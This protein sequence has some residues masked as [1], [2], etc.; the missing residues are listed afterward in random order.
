MSDE[1]TNEIQRLKQALRLPESDILLFGDG[2]GT[3]I[4]S[5]CGWFATAFLKKTSSVIEFW[6]GLSS[7]TNNVAELL[8]Y[9]FAMWH[10][11]AMVSAADKD[12][13][14]RRKISVVIVSDSEV[15]VKCG[16]G[17]YTRRANAP[18]WASIRWFEE[19]GYQFQWVHV[20]R[21]SN[22]FNLKA[23]VVAKRVRSVLNSLPQ[24]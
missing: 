7:G 1:N 22:V 18:L 8:P 11:D 9:V 14:S 5:S 20:P 12:W 15:T 24:S 2:A 17:E 10:L 16:N 13:E 19:K 3:C 23:D 4:G 6:G 21:N